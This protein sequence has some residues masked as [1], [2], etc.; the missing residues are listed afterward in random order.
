MLEARGLGLSRQ[1]RQLFCDLDFSLESGQALLV[2]GRNGS[3]KTSLLRIL[4]G[5][6]LADEGQ[7][8]WQQESL[9]DSAEYH[10]HMLYIGHHAAVNLELSPYENLRYL[11]A[12]H[13]GDSE[14]IIDILQAVGLAGYEDVP[15]GHLSAGQQRR[16][17]LSRLWLSD[18]KL[19]ILDEPLTA[20][21][22]K[23]VAGLERK[24]AA[25]LQQGGMLIVTTHQAAI[26]PS[27]STIRLKLGDT[28]H[29]ELES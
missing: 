22:V 27:E 28:S 15:A 7:L 3:G 9:Q 26:L 18:A 6:T 20:L 12:L 5:L 19:W 17:A 11:C 25:H 24:F 16:I 29:E 10:S 14:S 2:E 13:D 4:A 23:A 8:F 21:D 1:S